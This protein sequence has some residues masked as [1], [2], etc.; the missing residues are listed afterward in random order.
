MTGIDQGLDYNQR[1]GDSI[2]L[3]RLTVRGRVNINPAATNSLVRIMVVR[4]LA[5]NGTAP[6]SGDVLQVSGSVGA[7]LSNVLWI[8]KDRFSI[9]YDELFALSSILSSGDATFL[10]NILRLTLAMYAI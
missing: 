1:V 5:Q 4:D 7:P 10:L 2:K 9:L 8:N 6:V 3:Q